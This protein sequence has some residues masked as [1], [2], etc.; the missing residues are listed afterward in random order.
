MTAGTSITLTLDLNETN[1]VLNALGTQPFVQV[2]PLIEK[3][4]SQAQKQIDA[5]AAADA[6]SSV[7]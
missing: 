1:A 7:N 5:Q 3:I 6:P 4:R 2:A